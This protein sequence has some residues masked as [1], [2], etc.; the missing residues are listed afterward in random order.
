MSSPCLTTDETEKRATA[1]L[2]MSRHVMG[3]EKGKK[4]DA[5]DQESRIEE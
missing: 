1:L 4:L 2:G 3:G 5:K